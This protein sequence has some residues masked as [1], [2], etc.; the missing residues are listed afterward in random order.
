MN[1]LHKFWKTHVRF[2]IPTKSVRQ[3]FIKFRKVVARREVPLS[4]SSFPHKS[5]FFYIC[6]PNN[7]PQANF[8]S[9]LR[10]SSHPPKPQPAQSTITFNRAQHMVKAPRPWIPANSFLLRSAPRDSLLNHPLSSDRACANARG[11]KEN[12]LRWDTV[13]RRLLS[14]E[15]TSTWLHIPART[16]PQKRYFRACVPSEMNLPL[17]P[18]VARAPRWV[19]PSASSLARVPRSRRRQRANLIYRALPITP[20]ALPR[21]SSAC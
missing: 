14:I 11:E 10:E 19:S 4:I 12:V 3:I 17:R 13:N 20:R 9:L 6:A 8:H 5:R 15:H 21:P 2:V 1:I 7:I 18:S 16:R